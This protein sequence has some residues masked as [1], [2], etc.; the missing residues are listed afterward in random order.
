MSNVGAGGLLYTHV[1]VSVQNPIRLRCRAVAKLRFAMGLGPG[2]NYGHGQ[3]QQCRQAL[4][5]CESSQS[6]GAGYVVPYDQA[7]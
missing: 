4:I 2:G 3:G 1:L 5:W 6:C 7:S